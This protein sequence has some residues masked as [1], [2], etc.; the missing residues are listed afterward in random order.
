MKRI[1][2]ILSA[3]LLTGGGLSAQSNQ[4]ALKENNR[5]KAAKVQ[6]E[7]PKVN[8]HAKAI[9]QRFESMKAKSGES[10]FKAFASKSYYDYLLNVIPAE[11]EMVFN[12][13]ACEQ[14]K[15]LPMVIK[16]T[17]DEPVK[18]IIAGEKP[19]YKLNPLSEDAFMELSFVNGYAYG[20]SM[21]RNTCVKIDTSTWEVVE[22]LSDDLYCITQWGN[23][24]WAVKYN[25]YEE[26]GELV[27]LDDNMNPTETAI[28][29][30][31]DYN[32]FMIAADGDNLL[33]YGATDNYSKFHVEAY[34]AKGEKV[35]DYGSVDYNNVIC[36]CFN[37]ATR[38]IWLSGCYS[39]MMSLEYELGNGKLE[40]S[41]AI[42][43]YGMTPYYYVAFDAN[44][45][46]YLVYPYWFKSPTAYF[47][48]GEILPFGQSLS[49]SQ[50][51][52]NLQPGEQVTI[53]VT[54]NTSA[55]STNFMIGGF[56]F[57]NMGSQ[58][59]QYFMREVKINLDAEIEY[60]VSDTV[61]SSFANYTSVDTVWLKNTGC[62]PFY[63]EEPELYD[64]NYFSIIGVVMP[65]NYYEAGLR[66]GER[67]GAVVAFTP[68]SVGQFID[69]I[70]IETPSGFVT[71]ALIGSASALD[72]EIAERTIDTTF[73]ECLTTL[74]VADK[75]TNKSDAPMTIMSTIADVTFKVRTGDFEQEYVVWSLYDTDYNLV[76]DK[77][78][79]SYTQA[80]TDYS[81]SLS[82]S[83]GTYI[84]EMSNSWIGGYISVESNGEV[85]VPETY[86]YDWNQ[87]IFNVTK[88]AWSVTIAPKSSIDSL[89]IPAK[90]LYPQGTTQLLVYFEGLADAVDE[91]D[92]IAV[93][94][95][96][97]L[98]VD[99]TLNFGDVMNGSWEE[100]VLTIAN[101][102]CAP[103]HVNEMYFKGWIPGVSNYF[104]VY[105]EEAG[106]F[107]PYY[108]AFDVLPY[109]T[110]AIRTAVYVDS[111]G[112]FADT[113]VIKIEDADSVEVKMSATAVGAP[114][115]SFPN[116]SVK[117]TISFGTELSTVSAMVYN[118]GEA[119][120]VIN[121]PVCISY[122]AGRNHNWCSFTLLTDKGSYVTSNNDGYNMTEYAYDMKPG[123]YKLVLDYESSVSDD[124]NDSYFSIT[125]GSDT[126]V[127]KKM[128]KDL[129]SYAYYGQI[130][131]YGRGYQYDF[132][133]TD[134]MFRCDTV[135]PG[136]SLPLTMNIL[137]GDREV[138]EHSVWKY[139]TTN[140]PNNSTLGMQAIVLING[141]LDIVVPDT[142]DLGNV[143]V[144]MFGEQTIHIANNG[145]VEFY[146]DSENI[147]GADAD[148][149]RGN[150]RNKWGDSRILTSYGADL[151]V[152][153]I[154]TAEG[155][156]EAQLALTDGDTTITITL[157]GTGV[158]LAKPVFSADT[159]RLKAEC[160]QKEVKASYTITNNS[161]SQMQFASRPKLKVY[162]GTGTHPESIYVTVYKQNDFGGNSTVYYFPTNTYTVADTTYETLLDLPVGDYR[163]ELRDNQSY[164]YSNGDGRVSLTINDV[165][166][167]EGNNYNRWGTSYYFTISDEDI[168]EDIVVDANSST[169]VEQ[170]YSLEGL[171][172]GENAFVRI[173]DRVNGLGL[174]DTV[175]TIVT[176]DS[177]YEY[178]FDKE[179][180]EF[181][182]SHI[183]DHAY[184][185]VVI[186]NTGC[187]YVYIND[188][189]M[190]VGNYIYCDYSGSTS[191]AP[192]EIGKFK[193]NFYSEE[194]GKYKDALIIRTNLG[195]DVIPIVAT[196]TATQ[197]VS[198]SPDEFNGYYNAGDT[199]RINVTFDQMVAVFG[200]SEEL[201]KIKMN[202]GS[203]AVADS[204]VFDTNR[205]NIYSL[206]FNY[207]VKEDD[208]IAKLDYAEDSIYMVGDTLIVWN[209]GPIKSTTLPAVGSFAS[210]YSLTLDN[211]APTFEVSTSAT[212]STATLT[213]A[214]DEEVIGFVKSDITL[215][216]GAA[217][218]A[219]TT[220]DNKTFV[221]E[222]SLAHA[223][224]TNISIA[225]TVADL[226]GNEAQFTWTGSLA[227]VHDYDTTVVE[228]TFDNV[229][230][231]KLVCKICGETIYIDTVPAL[232]IKVV[233][234]AL[235]KLPSK[236]VYTKG[237]SLDVTGGQITITFNNST[238]KVIDLQN[239]MVSGFDIEAVGKQTLTVTYTDGVNTFTA[240]FDIEIEEGSAVAEE[241]A[242]EV[243]IY[244][245]NNT[246]VVEAAA[247]GSEIVVFDMN[248][249]MVAK[250]LATS[251]RTE[252]QMSKQGVYVVRIGNT[253]Q[254]VA[255]N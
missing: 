86:C 70:G 197:V 2:F 61:F 108:G 151:T 158:A 174:A 119:D 211:I 144:G 102:G 110:K 160:G 43:H 208:N 23:S 242:A 188:Y 167:V 21:N 133:V 131:N 106:D 37:P 46:G 241:A 146:V 181:V 212:V 179:Q 80:N 244:A 84:L 89:S 226:A 190:A 148:R 175:V 130:I 254:S 47:F 63:M 50:K 218:S 115:A 88:G 173:F 116:Y 117:D 64:G 227:T 16:N 223:V 127:G 53:N 141:D 198:V 71:A 204:S 170:T 202:T 11:E 9:K 132:T 44:G 137:L 216:E 85:L 22:T 220:A 193:F 206:V 245:F 153:F 33:V 74:A 49:L 169:K 100:K 45:K 152:R 163:L 66:S 6:S 62:Q 122:N 36:P 219:L 139:F 91:I 135:A 243:S 25:R 178:T 14:T 15:T 81:T 149:F 235:T 79:G 76:Y 154:P 182:P 134:D 72:Y 237:E 231:K 107:K 252:I 251:S 38:T 59:S 187:E 24:L 18:A 90:A 75:I 233:S 56:N 184:A 126:I 210:L 111:V 176:I 82:L 51:K 143:Q 109:S 150:V 34:N 26:K 205:D 40:L 232:E 58:E 246:I 225:T 20:F 200:N 195:A 29:L 229:G 55:G 165:V 112:A 222:L 3:L 32:G 255:I 67:I 125:C 186:E 172:G 96:S 69:S 4:Q 35:T 180:V 129:K 194:P 31:T 183:G 203:F 94:G 8:P 99:T 253:A 113:L 136:D 57:E 236:V 103:I 228:P 215:S 161:T 201:P 166:I 98:A 42:I 41:D 1:L 87:A 54:T 28:N 234:V 95:Q 120:L 147:T 78:F 189:Y 105:F 221:A 104:T 171:T 128:M 142:I 213:V 157:T 13:D 12:F 248:G 145:G 239:I 68:D 77:P 93:G 118:T 140:D 164:G 247:D 192:G 60:E 83:T 162:T 155:A 39:G 5:T 238:T 114:E 124:D 249:R 101:N 177:K 209:E 207:V 7:S 10:A 185:S 73:T 214:F 191:L 30:E 217:V 48:E 121:E 230:Y 17:S 156:A 27:A 19:D 52:I 196:A 159:I 65:D 123:N 168:Y 224:V 138:G 97:E 250:T 92:V 199:I 240:T